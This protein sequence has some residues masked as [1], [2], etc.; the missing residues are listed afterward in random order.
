MGIAILDC[1]KETV[2]ILADLIAEQDDSPSPYT[3]KDKFLEMINPKNHSLAIISDDFLDV[4]EGTKQVYD[5]IEIVA[6]GMKDGAA[7]LKAGASYFL[8]KP[9]R[10][11]E[12]VNVI[13]ALKAPKGQ[14]FNGQDTSFIVADPSMREIVEVIR[15]VAPTQASVLIKGESGTGKEVVARNIH[16]LSKR[17][18]GPY[19]GIN[20]A[21]IPETL[22]ESELF[23]YEKGAFTGAYATR[24]G[25]FE[26]ADCGTILL[27]EVTEITPTLQA[28]L[29]RV[30]QERQI[31]RVGGKAPIK[32]DFRVISTTNRDI[33]EEIN[34][35]RFRHD[36]FFRLN[37]ITIKIPP[38]RERSD[39]ILP[40][41]TH[42][43][44]A[45]A[46]RE[47]MREKVL[48]KEAKDALLKYPWPGNV[49][50]LENVV[51][52]AMILTEEDIISAEHIALGSDG[53]SISSSMPA[54][55]TTIHD[56]EKNLIYSTL[57]KVD[58]NR[59]KAATL[60]G[61]SIRTL[62]N[63]LHEYNNG[64]QFSDDDQAKSGGPDPE[65]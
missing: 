1:D 24:I 57:K 2:N 21:A 19:V 26:Q 3:D 33:E 65:E 13:K 37:V 44:K 31:D 43:I 46:S 59:T 35:G 5:S 25:R 29:L 50:E 17:K 45:V 16:A 30:L 4:I 12:M 8:K 48:S 56:M 10:A 54:T 39:D 22:L 52:R 47:D 36:L 32:V 14:K 51:E 34:Q 42:F 18:S 28:K 11:D 15:K 61:I 6:I 63:K 7:C 55:G 62:R 40:L 60:L 27:D 23:G 64:G 20:L 9:F 58:G 38:L 53:H 41:T 49:R